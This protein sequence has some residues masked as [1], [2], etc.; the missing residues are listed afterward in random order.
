MSLTVDELRGS[1]S[2]LQNNCKHLSL[3]H[4]FMWDKSGLA[5][6]FY[7]FS[8]PMSSTGKVIRAF[9]YQHKAVEFDVTTSVKNP[10][11]YFSIKTLTLLVAQLHAI[12]EL[13]FQD[14]RIDLYPFKNGL[15]D[16]IKRDN[17]FKENLEKAVEKF[18]LFEKAQKIILAFHA[19]FEHEE[20]CN[21]EKVE[22]V[23]QSIALRQT[24]LDL[25]VKK[26]E[27]LA[28]ESL[29]QSLK[30]IRAQM[31]TLPKRRKT[32]CLEG[33]L[34]QQ[35][36]QENKE[37]KC[38]LH[39]L[40][41]EKRLVEESI[42]SEIPLL[43]VTQ[44]KEICLVLDSDRLLLKDLQKSQN[45]YRQTYQE[46]LLC[47]LQAEGVSLSFYNENLQ[48]FGYERYLSYKLN[49]IAK[50]LDPDARSLVNVK[51]PLLVEDLIKSSTIETSQESRIYPPYTTFNILLTF[52]WKKILSGADVN[53]YFNELSLRILLCL[54]SHKAILNK[55]DDFENYVLSLY[56]QRVYNAFFPELAIT[57]I[58]RASDKGIETFPD[59]GET[60]IRNFINV[61]IKDHKKKILNADFL[62]NIPFPVSKGVIAFYRKHSSLESISHQNTH[63]DWAKLISSF[64]QDQQKPT[65]SYTKPYLNPFYELKP[66][67]RNMLH[68]L[69]KLL[70]VEDIG[71]FVEALA[72]VKGEKIECCLD[73]FFPDRFDLND[74]ENKIILTFEDQH[75][76]EWYFL[77]QHFRTKLFEKTMNRQSFDRGL[78]KFEPYMVESKL[79][80][81]AYLNLLALFYKKET[82][83]KEDAFYT[84]EG[85]SESDQFFLHLLTNLDSVETLDQ[86][87]LT[88]L[89]KKSF[90]NNSSI[91][92]SVG[93]MMLK[94]PNDNYHYAK[95][96]LYAK[97]IES[98]E[99]IVLQHLIPS[100]KSQT[101]S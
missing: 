49:G 18:T 29:K 52:L 80:Q 43:Y 22:R 28:P 96:T 56:E 89:E 16:K 1:Y 74:Y 100:L 66:G 91:A 40:E 8:D 51:L 19:Q 94:I 95:R 3:L 88:L 23:K 33:A 97:L 27:S 70:G 98:N 32:G 77:K 4:G 31:K 99:L 34:L 35:A 24:E 13:Y 64:N 7:H 21:K 81:N 61:L 2:I 86:M 42:L 87:I 41:T 5:E 71:Q 93:E 79:T 59:C 101:V 76:F 72:K 82:F 48:I 65:I 90:L 75:V 6:K 53:D 63:N 9:F 36:I 26:I 62:E 58:S 20:K 37:I 78:K 55:E 12:Q 83:E 69:Q 44:K 46:R 47:R 25:C 17:D 60:S 85:L 92:R 14:P 54:E 10:V 68:V 84:Q 45:E 39:R 15:I 11:Y 30:T 73:H 57:A 67:G 38:G 50:K